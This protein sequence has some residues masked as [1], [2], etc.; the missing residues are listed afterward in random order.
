MAPDFVTY[1]NSQWN[2]DNSFSNWKIYYSKSG[3][4]IL[5]IGIKYYMMMITEYVSEWFLFCKTFFKTH[6]FPVLLQQ[7]MLLNHSIPS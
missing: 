6:Y 7:I 2:A 4:C 3:K 5:N 1:F